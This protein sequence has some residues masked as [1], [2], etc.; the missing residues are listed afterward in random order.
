MPQPGLRGPFA[1]GV[2]RRRTAPRGFGLKLT[3][4]APLPNP[5][6]YPAFAAYLFAPGREARRRE[7]DG[8]ELARLGKEAK[9]RLGLVPPFTSPVL[10]LPASPYDLPDGAAFLLNGLISASPGSPGAHG[11][12][13]REWADGHLTARRKGLRSFSPSPPLQ[14]SPHPKSR[15]RRSRPRTKTIGRWW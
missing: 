10:L 7:V 14:A 11:T 13:W 15:T 4:R 5:D 6:A 9:V 8:R 3:A 12:S 1:L 2:L